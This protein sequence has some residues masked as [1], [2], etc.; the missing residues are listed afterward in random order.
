MRRRPWL[1]LLPLVVFTGLVGVFYLGIRRDNP[2]ELPT[3]L[4]GKAAPALRVAPLGN[5]PLLTDAAL[6][7][8]GLSLV[9]FW[10]SWCTPCRVEHPTLM[11]LAA[12][13]VPIYGVNYKDSNGLRFLQ[14]LG[15]PFAAI[16]SD[17]QGHTA[18]EWGVYGVPESFVVDAQ[19]RIVMRIAGP[20]TQRALHE[21]LRPIIEP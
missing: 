6:R 3:A 11:Q 2:D 7:E 8:G 1:W 21:R 15:D 19:G 20:L 5:K 9:N 17:P 14:S 4:A 13:G 16:G 10:A 18:I 12:E